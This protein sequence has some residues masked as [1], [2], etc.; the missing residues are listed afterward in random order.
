MV[1]K[2]HLTL[3]YYVMLDMEALKHSWRCFYADF[4]ILEFSLTL[5]FQRSDSL[6][7]ANSAAHLVI[8]LAEIL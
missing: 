1:G 7:L 2:S 6:I 8:S 5:Y 3:L 4:N